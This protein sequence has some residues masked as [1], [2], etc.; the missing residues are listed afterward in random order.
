[1]TAF[2]WMNKQGLRSETGFEFQF[3]DRFSAEYRENGVITTLYVEGGLGVITIYEDSIQHLW[4]NLPKPEL[5]QAERHRIIGNLR[6]ALAFQDL[7]LDLAP[8]RAPDF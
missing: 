6:D 8:G 2:T 7:R 1:M 5:R 3:T 4:M